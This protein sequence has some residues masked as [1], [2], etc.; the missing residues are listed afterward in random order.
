MDGWLDE[1]LTEFGMDGLE[2]Q[3]SEGR[4][5]DLLRVTGCCLLNPEPL[6]LEP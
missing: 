3:K 2:D 6:N 1:F 4:G 5:Q